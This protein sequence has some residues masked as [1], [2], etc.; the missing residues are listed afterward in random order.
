MLAILLIVSLA[1]LIWWIWQRFGDDLKARWIEF[2]RTPEIPANALTKIWSQFHRRIPLAMKRHVRRYP[3]YLVMGDDRSGKSKLIDSCGFLNVQGYRYHPNLDDSDFMKVYLG[4]ESLIIELSA[5]FLYTNTID[6]ANAL[7]RLWKKLPQN[8]QLVMTIDAHQLMHGNEENQTRTAEALMGKL[9]LFSEYNRDAVSFSLVLTHM[10]SIKGFNSFLNFAVENQLDFFVH[11]SESKPIANFARGLESYTRY[12][13]AALVSTDSE[14]F[15]EICNF[16]MTARK[17]LGALQTL[18][19]L[20]CSRNTIEETRLRKVCLISADQRDKSIGLIENNPF[21][22]SGFSESYLDNLSKKHLKISSWLVGL[23]LLGSS[24]SFIDERMTINRAAELIQDMP[25]ITMRSYAEVVHP[26]FRK[27]Y[28][29]HRHLQEM[30]YKFKGFHFEHYPQQANIVRRHIAGILRKTYLIPQL[31]LV[32][33]QERI[34]SRTIVLLALLHATRNNELG[35]YFHLEADADVRMDPPLPGELVSDY[36][37]FNTDADEADLFELAIK[38]YGV[39]T[40]INKT[41]FPWSSSDLMSGLADMLEDPYIDE[42]KLEDIKASSRAI[43]ARVDRSREYPY[44]DE[45]RLWLTLHGHVSPETLAQWAR[46]PT[47]A[48]VNASGVIQALKLITSTTIDP[49]RLPKNFN[50]LLK[51]IQQTIDEGKLL[52]DENKIGIV[53]IQ[54]ANQT[55]HFDTNRWLVLTLRSKVNA[56]L[57]AYYDQNSVA[58]GWIFF[59]QQEHSTKIALGISTDESGVLINNAQVDVRLTREGFE[60]NVKPAVESMSA[61]IDVIPLDIPERQELLNYFIRNLSAYSGNYANAYWSFFKNMVIRIDDADHLVT[62]LKELQRPGSAFVQNL[63]RV[64]EN[65]LLDLP[66]GP[67]YQPIRDRLEDFNFLKKLMTEQAGS[68]PELN[69]YISIIS[70][71]YISLVANEDVAP[72][73]TDKGAQSAVGLKAVL[74][75]IGRVAY[76]ILT[77]ADGSPLRLVDGWLRDLSIP[78]SW[79]GPFLAPVLKARDFGRHDVNVIINRQWTELW[80]HDVLP[81]FSSFPFD[82]TRGGTAGDLSPESLNTV[83]HPTNGSFWIEV[84]RIFGVLFQ[85][86][87]GRW[88][89]R[90]DIQRAFQIPEGMP[91]RLNAASNLTLALWD[92]DSQPKPLTFKLRVEMIPETKYMTDADDIAIKPALVYLRSGSSSALGFNQKSLWQEISMEWWSKGSANAGIE[93]DSQDEKAKKYAS[94]DLDDSRWALLKLISQAN[95]AG[96]AYDWTVALLDKPADKLKT[97]VIFKRDPFELFNALKNR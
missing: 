55:Y 14:S 13:S 90:P 88:T 77:G 54:L 38:P 41:I 71:L 11:L 62:Y 86:Q 47:V 5:S 31:E 73:P 27:L 17:T 65:V 79:R 45:E 64:K 67:N 82:H 1:A 97:T 51:Q 89:V 28:Q 15:V 59:D 53:D 10:D 6:H 8:T 18:M 36:I 61:L 48:Q 70:G 52:I 25:A 44:L 74:S 91:E 24:Y 19:S 16:L 94:V 87:E 68:Y 23:L 49:P 35:N 63:I 4:N 50:H 56:M 95:H 57:N 9:A 33:K 32:Q 96:L 66:V 42:D 30:Q 40:A 34:Y 46:F 85:I 58:P 83:F 92:K 21:L 39:I 75:P 22:H 93:F 78:D 80:N 60:N 12:G 43:L 3:V 37:E 72:A 76:D 69:R 20:A 84:R 29:E 2:R 26:T 7:L 81:L